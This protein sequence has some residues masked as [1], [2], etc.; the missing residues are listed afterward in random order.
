MFALQSQSREV[1][2][3][4]LDLAG[5]TPP[6]CQINV[7]VVE[8]CVCFLRLPGRGSASS[9]SHGFLKIDKNIN[10]LGAH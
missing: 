7:L 4:R 5:A 10:Y 9:L 8:Y 3:E 1:A 2:D 6:D